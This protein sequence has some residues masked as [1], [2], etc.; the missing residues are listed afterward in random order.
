[1]QNASVLMKRPSESMRVLDIPSRSDRVRLRVAWAMALCGFVMG[2]SIA[3]AVWAAA[4]PDKSG[5]SPP[6]S[7]EPKVDFEFQL[8]NISSPRQMGKLMN[9]FVKWRYPQDPTYCPFSP[10]DNTCIQYQLT[11]RQF[12]LNVTD[13]IAGPPVESEWERVALFLCRHFYANERIVA[14]SVLVQ[15][16]GDG[17]SWVS[18]YEPGAHGSTCT[19]GPP[20]FPPLQRWNPLPDYVDGDDGP[21]APRVS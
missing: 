20:D 11:P 16:N 6:S 19:I 10:T 12:I 4:R 13:G 8:L 21:G 18:A 5:I 1:M 9:I 17:R 2:A 7:S 15:V 3:S 14:V